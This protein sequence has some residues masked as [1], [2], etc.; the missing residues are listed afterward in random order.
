M[1]AVEGSQS[2]IYDLK[3]VPAHILER[4]G[5]VTSLLSLSDTC[6]PKSAFGNVPEELC[7]VDRLKSIARYEQKNI[8]E[9]FEGS[10]EFRKAVIEMGFSCFLNH[11]AIFMGQYSANDAEEVVLTTVESE[12][13]RN[14]LIDHLTVV[15]SMM[16]R[17]SFIVKGLYF[18]KKKEYLAAVLVILAQLEGIIADYLEERGLA[19]NAEGA[20][21]KLDSCGDYCLTKKKKKNKLVGLSNKIDRIDKPSGCTMEVSSYFNELAMYPIDNECNLYTYRN[22]IMHG[23]KTIIPTQETSAKLMYILSGCLNIFYGYL[24]F[25]KMRDDNVI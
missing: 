4:L 19:L 24:L 11:G 10:P 9:L 20:V 23:D 1:K 17:T 25:Q 7:K 14:N 18:H 5:T 16:E 15:P 22:R 2:P 8:V 6:F 12:A 3:E 13:F 21:Y